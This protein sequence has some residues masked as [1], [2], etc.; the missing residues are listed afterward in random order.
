LGFTTFETWEKY[1]RSEAKSGKYLLFRQHLQNL[2]IQ[3]NPQLML[4]GTIDV[5]RA[6]LIYA[7][8]DEQEMGSF[9]NMQRY[10]L[11]EAPD[12]C[13]VFTFDLGGR[14]FA[15]ILAGSNLIYPD[16]ADIYNH[17]WNDLKRVGYRCVWISRTDG[18]P[19]TPEQLKDL[20]EEVSDDL[21]F[22]YTEDEVGFWF[23]SS[24]SSYLFVSIDDFDDCE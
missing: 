15:R 9:L 21:R 8:I 5:V 10:N 6:T 1:F 20:E 4:K 14:A 16:L 17:P 13:Y 11:A 7:Q 24:N 3:G 2:G 22:D 12:S 19:L 18:L 23:D